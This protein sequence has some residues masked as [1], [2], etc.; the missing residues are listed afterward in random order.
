MGFNKSLKRPFKGLPTASRNS[1][2]LS[3]CLLRGLLK[4][5]QFFVF[6]PLEYTFQGILGIIGKLQL[7]HILFILGPIG[8]AM[9]IEAFERPL[10]EHRSHFGSSSSP[11]AS[12][13]SLWG[14]G[15]FTDKGA[16]SKSSHAV[17]SLDEFYLGDA[18]E[19][20]CHLGN[21]IEKLAAMPNSGKSTP[22]IA[23]GADLNHGGTC[24]K[25]RF[26]VLLAFQAK[27]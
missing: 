14:K 8:P 23:Q 20:V 10:T 9:R 3:K 21:A 6:S 18:D 25:D 26:D 15:G 5:L 7:L 24:G 2:G 11:F 19:D 13:I 1:K 12:L 4:A 17:G 22:G 27:K 16:A